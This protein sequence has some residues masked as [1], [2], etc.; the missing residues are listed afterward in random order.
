MIDA[1]LSAALDAIGLAGFLLVI[2][3]LAV[4]AGAV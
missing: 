1:L 2:A 3:A 4:A